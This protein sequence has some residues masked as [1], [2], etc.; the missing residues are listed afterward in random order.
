MVFLEFYH[1]HLPSP[2]SSVMTISGKIA[3]N[4]GLDLNP[5]PDPD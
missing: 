1:M 5:R 3:D 4:D 2:A